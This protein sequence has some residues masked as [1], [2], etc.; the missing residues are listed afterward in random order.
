MPTLPL[1]TPSLLLRHFVPEDAQTLRV[2]NAEPTTRTWLPSHVYRTPAEAAGRIGFL[3]D[4]YADPGDP[5]RGPYVLG[6]EHLKTGQLLGHVG[7]SPLDDDVEISYAIAQ[8]WRG[9]GLGTEAIVAACAW[10]AAVFGLM[11]ILALTAPANAA[12]RRTLARAG[13]AH[14]GDCVRC[15]QGREQSVSTY[16]CALA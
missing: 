16:V 10:A 2:L 14:I 4:Q 15:F 1:S 12:S 13:F 6:V 11:R 8:A 5:K 3:I 7:F 9:R